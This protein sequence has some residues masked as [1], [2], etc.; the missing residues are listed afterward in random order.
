[1]DTCREKLF[2]PAVTPLLQFISVEGEGPVSSLPPRVSC[3]CAPSTVHSPTDILRWEKR[4]DSVTGWAIRKDAHA[5][6]RN[7]GNVKGGARGLTVSCLKGV[8]PN[9]VL[10]QWSG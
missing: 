9:G 4:S 7:L 10:F 2:P 5:L 8:T 3:S 1:M 6:S